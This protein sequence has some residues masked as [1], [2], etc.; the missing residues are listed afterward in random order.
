M[1]FVCALSR[2]LMPSVRCQVL[3]TR[4]LRIAGGRPKRA[5]NRPA[6]TRSKGRTRARHNFVT[7]DDNTLVRP[8]HDLVRAIAVQ[9]SL[10]ESR[11]LQER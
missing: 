7:C 9:C 4:R 1:G 11:I 2:E 8:A 3:L 5:E 6:S 10:N